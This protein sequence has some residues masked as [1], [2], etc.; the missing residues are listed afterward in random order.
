MVLAKNN[1]RVTVPLAVLAAQTS[2]WGRSV[3]EVFEVDKRKIKP[4]G[5]TDY[6]HGVKIPTVHRDVFGEPHLSPITTSLCVFGGTQLQVWN[7]FA[8]VTRNR[9]A[10]RGAGPLA[11]QLPTHE[12]MMI[13]VSV[14]LGPSLPLEPLS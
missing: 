1:L 11:I 4:L 5:L 13:E 2:L 7:H 9:G 8:C 12:V 10:G 6:M 3:D 14:P